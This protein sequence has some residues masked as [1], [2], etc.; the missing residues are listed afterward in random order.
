MDWV[1]RLMSGKDTDVPAVTRMMDQMLGCMND[2]LT[3]L[4]TSFATSPRLAHMPLKRVYIGTLMAFQNLPVFTQGLPVSVV[5]SIRQLVEAFNKNLMDGV[6]SVNAGMPAP[7]FSVVD[8]Y[9]PLAAA[10]AA[11]PAPLSVSNRPCLV[12]PSGDPL[13]A[14][15]VVTSRCTNPDSYFF[16]DS[17][18]LTS[19]AQKLVGF[20]CLL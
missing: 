16:Y 3:P 2:A 10:M 14:K 18:H 13:A 11:P 1:I 9:S 17:S 12:I 6:A 4:I 19:T 5:N 15:L 7:L 8:M 20:A